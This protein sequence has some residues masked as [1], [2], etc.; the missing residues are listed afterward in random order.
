MVDQLPIYWKSSESMG[1]IPD[2]GIQSVITSP[3][4][5][6]LKDYGHNEQIGAKGESYKDFHSR[7]SL[8][9]EQSFD[10]LADDGTLWIVA[11]TRMDH[12]GNL[13][14]LPYDIAENAK[15]YGFFLEEL[16]VWYKPTSLAR[17]NPRLLTNKK[18]YILLLSKSENPKINAGADPDNDLADPAISEGENTLGDMWRFPLKRGSLGRNI[19]HKAPFPIDLVKRMIRIS[20]EPGDWILDPF[21]GSGTTAEAALELDRKVCGYE[22][23]QDFKPIIEDRISN[24]LRPDLELTKWTDEE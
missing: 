23:N 20:S 1:E 17:M 21:L 11:N 15:T 6:D 10:K 22:I 16:I 12:K 13:R 2:G 5:Y 18:E 24:I 14:L 4:Y 3:P 9:W 8:V 19:L 7:L